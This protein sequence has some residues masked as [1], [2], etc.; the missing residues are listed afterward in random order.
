MSVNFD[1]SELPD[2]F[3][4]RSHANQLIIIHG[5]ENMFSRMEEGVHKSC[6]ETMSAEE[7]VRIQRWIEEGR[8]LEKDTV[9][10]TIAENV[11][12]SESLIREKATHQSLRDSL[13]E[14]VNR[15]MLERESSLRKDFE[16]QKLKEIIPLKERLGD[17]ELKEEMFRFMRQKIITLE[18]Q[19][20]E[21]QKK[22][23][24]LTES[25]TK[26]SHK[27]G[28]IGENEVMT[29]LESVKPLLPYATVENKTS[30][31]HAADFHLSVMGPRGN[32]IKMLIDAKKYKRRITTDEINKLIS[33][34]DEDEYAGCGMMI[35]IDSQIC[36]K[37][38]YQ[39]M[40]TPKMKPVM[41]VSLEHIETT[42]QRSIIC[43]AINT[44]ISFVNECSVFFKSH[45]VND[46]E[47][48]IKQLRVCVKEIEQ[49]IVLQTTACDTLKCTRDNL[50][51]QIE[52]IRNEAYGED[53]VVDDGNIEVPHT[54]CTAKKHKTH[55][56]CGAP[57]V[58]GQTKCK[59]HVG[60]RKVAGGAGLELV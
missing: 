25:K 28:V 11:K 40:N 15:R 36:G 54:G 42:H 8:K 44:L 13:E 16:L 46:I 18:Q 7:T 50:L 20:E 41:Y 22:L 43:C 47:P 6:S 57:V 5:G 9:I 12:L 45:T 59:H 2:S 38:Q 60:R 1:I 29:L 56:L 33:D 39:I 34:V 31:A 14:E 26:S 37:K 19:Y 23:L 10:S 53:E 52:D 58:P 17:V 3:C 48:F 24:E 27:I 49:T 51:K 55:L 30:V 35:S 21:N 4:K 32:M